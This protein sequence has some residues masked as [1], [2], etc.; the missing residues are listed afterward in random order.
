M[1]CTNGIKYCDFCGRETTECGPLSANINAN[2]KLHICLD[3]A[4]NALMMFLGR[5]SKKIPRGTVY[6]CNGPFRCEHRACGSCKHASLKE[7]TGSQ[8]QPLETL[9][10]LRISE[11][12]IFPDGLTLFLPE[13]REDFWLYLGEVIGWGRFCNEFRMRGETP[14]GRDGIYPF[15][16][17]STQPVNT[18][19]P[20]PRFV[21]R[22]QSL[23]PRAYFE[24]PIVV[25]S[26][27]LGKLLGLPPLKQPKNP[28]S[29]DEV[30]Q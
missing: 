9:A 26:S 3:C 23:L 22:F 8:E 7:L 2:G 19:F 24:V 27:D 30:S 20:I 16:L 18:Q 1:L 4:V 12:G 11:V 28:D 17:T 5:E 29:P 14:E 21:S 25:R 6:V 10:T 13:N 15:V